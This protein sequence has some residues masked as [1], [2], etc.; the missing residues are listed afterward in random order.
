MRT[1]LAI[2]VLIAG[3]VPAAAQVTARD[4]DLAIAAIA[5][6]ERWI[7]ARSAHRRFI[8]LYDYRSTRIVRKPQRS[9]GCR[10]SPYERRC[11]S[12]IVY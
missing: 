3:L 6:Q 7:A 2:V 8:E 9:G 1:A 11:W 5:A 4:V 10:W 12:S